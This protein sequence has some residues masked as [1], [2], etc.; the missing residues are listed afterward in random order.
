[1]VEEFTFRDFYLFIERTV[2]PHVILDSS[3]LDQ[4][5]VLQRARQLVLLLNDDGLGL[6]LQLVVV[7]LLGGVQ[8]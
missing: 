3:S 1:M 2:T 6:D 7:L 5:H 8:V 4:D